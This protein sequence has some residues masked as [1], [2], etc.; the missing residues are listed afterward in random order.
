MSPD[1][2]SNLFA[3]P[4]PPVP[5]SARP[6]STRHVFAVTGRIAL[7]RRARQDARLRADL[8][9]PTVSD[10]QRPRP[11]LAATLSFLWPG[12]G[13]AYAARWLLAAILGLPI[14]ALAVY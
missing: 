4:V 1:Q 10:A 14:I 6:H 12:L 11:L 13:H 3:L 2:R 9:D 7:R 5:R 8:S